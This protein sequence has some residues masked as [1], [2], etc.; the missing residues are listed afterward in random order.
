MSTYEAVMKADVRALRDALG[1]L[2][3]AVNSAQHLTNRGKRI[4]KSRL[5]AEAERVQKIA[6]RFAADTSEAVLSA[7]TLYHVLDAMLEVVILATC[8]K[9]DRL[10][11]CGRARRAISKA[12]AELSEPA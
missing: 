9:A 2:R 10:M 5:I 8:D 6:R 4:P 7:E 1:D 11:R 12:Y 3:R